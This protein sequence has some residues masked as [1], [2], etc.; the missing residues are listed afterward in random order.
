MTDYSKSIGR[1]FTDP[2]TQV[3]LA[4]HQSVRK[5]DRQTKLGYATK[6]E[7]AGGFKKKKKKDETA[8]GVIRQSW[9]GNA[10]YC[11]R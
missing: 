4:E 7:T 1:G 5:S 6:D 10:M 3:V 9:H 11:T 8:G 2:P